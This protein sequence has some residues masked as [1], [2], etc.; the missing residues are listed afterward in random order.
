MMSLVPRRFDIDD[1]FEDFF[2][3]ENKTLNGM[4][5]DIYEKDGKNHLEMDLPGFKKEDIKIESDNGYITITAE[6]KKENN[7]KDKKYIRRERSYSKYQ[8]SFYI[9]D[10]AS[11]EIKADFKDGILNI[12]IPVLNEKESKKQISID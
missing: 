3:V 8:R 2:P 9:G 7:D 6:S 10:V 1:F 11:E 4:K 12:V 5:C